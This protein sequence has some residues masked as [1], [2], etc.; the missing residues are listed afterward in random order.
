MPVEARQADGAAALKLNQI[1]E[2]LVD[3]ARQHHE[4]HA[5][6]F[7]VRHAHAVDE[8]AFLAHFAEH[9]GDLRPAAVHQ[10]DLHADQ[11]QQADIAG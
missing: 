7:L 1:H 5:D 10:H 4:R 2:R 8:R 6:G 3:L 11:L 9:I